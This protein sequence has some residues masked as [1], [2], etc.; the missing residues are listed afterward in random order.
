MS[1]LQTFNPSIESQ[2]QHQRYGL[3][4]QV[5][6]TSKQQSMSQD[7]QFLAEATVSKLQEWLAEVQKELVA[8]K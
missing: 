2:L 7:K 3:V 8:D 6:Q 4:V 1:N 5:A